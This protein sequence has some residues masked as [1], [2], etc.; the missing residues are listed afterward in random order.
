MSASGPRGGVRDWLRYLA[1]TEPRAETLYDLTGERT[2]IADSSVPLANMGY[3]A[4]VDVDG[5]HS[6]ER[7]NMALFDLVAEA[8]GLDRESACVVDV[9]AGFGV[10]GVRVAA[11]WPGARVVGVNL[12]RV[13]LDLARRHARSRGLAERVRFVRADARTLPFGDASVDRVLCVEAAFHFPERPRFFA[14]V[15]RVLKPGGRLSM[16][17]LVPLPPRGVAD[18]IAW[19]L[20]RRG[21]SVPDDNVQHPDVYRAQLAR[22]GLRVTAFRSIAGDVYPPFRRWQLSRPLRELVRLPPMMAL[23]SVGFLFYPW[24]YLQIVAEPA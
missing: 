3:W 20:T 23:S 9:G 14:E 6:L 21:L 13:Q 24:D 22:A 10:N 5:P 19:Q 12:S 1:S 4:N 15:R 8:A 2:L 11:R 18:R 17:D 16:V 7:A